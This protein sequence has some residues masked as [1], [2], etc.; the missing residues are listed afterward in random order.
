VSER[1]GSVT[2]FTSEVGSIHRQRHQTHLLDD[3]PTSCEISQTHL[4][5][6]SLLYYHNL[7]ANKAGVIARL[8]T[9]E[10]SVCFAE[11]SEEIQSALLKTGHV[12][13]S[14][15]DEIALS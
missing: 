14:K 7:K 5:V 10:P 12:K 8:Q 3:D 15:F 9:K 13:R 6:S 2:E 11:M 4:R 1:S